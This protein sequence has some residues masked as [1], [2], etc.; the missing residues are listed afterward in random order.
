MNVYLQVFV[1]ALP[2]SLLQ[3]KYLSENSKKM[4]EE[5]KPSEL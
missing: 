2:V 5:N 4:V 1:S 3:A